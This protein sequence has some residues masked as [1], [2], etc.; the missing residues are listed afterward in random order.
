MCIES[1]VSSRDRSLSL[2]YILVI[3]YKADSEKKILVQILSLGALTV[4][5]KQP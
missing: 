4:Y 5:T 1:L 3:T 2:K